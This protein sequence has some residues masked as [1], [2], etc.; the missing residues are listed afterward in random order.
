LCLELRTLGSNITFVEGSSRQPRFLQENPSIGTGANAYLDSLGYIAMVDLAFEDLFTV[1][2]TLGESRGIGPP[3]PRGSLR[4]TRSPY[5][6]NEWAKDQVHGRGRRRA[7]VY[8][9][10][11]ARRSEL[12]A[13]GL[14]VELADPW[15]SF[16]KLLRTSRE[17]SRG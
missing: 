12:V 3:S 6:E 13:Q 2:E 14:R 10:W 17:S 9:E 7:K 4:E 8:R 11:L 1:L 16:K 5:P 15:D